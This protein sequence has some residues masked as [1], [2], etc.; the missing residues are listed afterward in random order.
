VCQALQ[1]QLVCLICEALLAVLYVA[2]R[3][4]VEANVAATQLLVNAD[5][6]CDRAATV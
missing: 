6:T 1:L 5:L 2:R 4:D 3:F